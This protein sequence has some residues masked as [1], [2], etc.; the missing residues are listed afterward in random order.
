[1]GDA[2]ARHD[3]IV[4][5]AIESH[6]GYVVKTTG[7]GFHAAF[8]S[9][10]DG[11]GAAVGAQLGLASESWVVTGPLR[12][13]MGVHSGEAEFRDG[14]YYGTALNRAARIM[15]AGHGGQ[16]LVSRATVELV[17][18]ALPEGTELIDLGEHRL[19]DLGRAEALLQVAHG[20]L[21][22]SFPPLRSLDAFPGNLPLQFTSFVGREEEMARVAGLVREARLVTLT[23]VG[24]VGKT[25]LALQVAAELVSEFRDGAWLCELASAADADAL[26]QVAAAALNVQP[27]ATLSLEER[28]WEA[29][30]EREAV[31]VLDNCEHLLERA[32]SFAGGLVRVCPG[33]RVIATS[34]EPLDVDG[35]RVV[36]VRSLPVPENSARSDA[37]VLFVERA[38]GVDAEFA[39]DETSEAAIAE[40]CRR[41]DGIPL[42]IELAAARVVAMTPEEIAQLLD[43]RFRLLTGGRRTA[44]ERHQTLRAT[45][46][47]SYSLLSE[48]ERVIFDRL[49]VFPSSFDIEAACAVAGG[50]G[51][52][53]WDVRDALRSLVTKSMVGTASGLRA[54]TRYQ[55]LETMRQY[56]RERLEETGD[57]DTRRRAHAVYFVRFVEKV[58]DAYRTGQDLHARTAQSRLEL[59]NYRAA[60]TWGLDSDTPG[61]A[62]YAL[63]IAVLFAGWEPFTRR[64]AG[65]ITHEDRL[66]ERA[67][68]S[69]PELLAGILAGM[70]NDALML[71]GDVD[72]AADLA[73]QA[74]DLG[75]TALGAIAMSHAVL[76]FCALARNQHDRAITIFEAGEYLVDTNHSQAFFEVLVSRAEAS[77]GNATAARAHAERA[78]RLARES[79]FSMR[80]AQA[81]NAL[82]I[83]TAYTDLEAARRVVEDALAAARDAGTDQGVAISLSY[84]A[85]LLATEGDVPGACVVLG[86]MVRAWGED[87]PVMALLGA[88]A[89][90]AAIFADAGAPRPAATLA[91]AVMAGPHSQLLLAAVDA[92]TREQLRNVI[93]VVR[94]HLEK[95]TFD[96]EWARGATMSSHEI[97]RFIGTTAK[98]LNPTASL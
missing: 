21:P 45:V 28:I 61:D 38:R 18:D 46:D 66:L 68:S 9:A 14:D 4:R 87:A 84:Q 85:E 91:G 96:N 76:G 6:H 31:I 67:R 77:R 16:V 26:V 75:P 22:R 39:V 56:A 97:M 7:D 60:M 40:I 11:L 27:H 57:A 34:R 19:R 20:D 29:F 25:R 69:A 15:G 13:R 52:D 12:V 74:L 5:E 47:W 93:E 86:D 2:L 65:L 98:E 42:A 59:D 35:E 70:A 83:A 49:G 51:I 1:M 23:G 82:A 89:R 10:R 36:R 55:L 58:A 81:L 95:D 17:G 53:E 24:G 44:V 78:V 79:Q 33:V 90:A 32:S 80:I 72:T 50:D 48:T 8:G 43:E 71:R 41:L 54:T 37:T 62:E 94:A 3:V 88:T 73:Q 92:R 64:A 30:R 63:R